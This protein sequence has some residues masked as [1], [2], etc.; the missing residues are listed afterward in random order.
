MKLELESGDVYEDVGEADIVEAIKGDGFAILG[1]DPMTYIQC[2]P[3]PETPA[4]FV[5]EYQDGSLKRHFHAIDA[6][7]TMDRVVGAFGKYLRKDPSWK[8]D[9]K[10]QKDEPM[11]S[12]E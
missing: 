12:F 10:W 6:P 3:H 8:R 7:V 2:A 11:E 4:E 9:F 1:D 5:L